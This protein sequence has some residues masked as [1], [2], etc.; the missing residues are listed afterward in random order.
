MPH[1]FAQSNAQLDK[2][3]VNT[4][5]LI[6]RVVDT[7]MSAY[8]L[9]ETHKGLF[10]T[11]IGVH[12]SALVHKPYKITVLMPLA[13]QLHQPVYN[14]VTFRTNVPNYLKMQHISNIP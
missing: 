5:K 8:L 3:C 13:V 7:K 9:D 14:D 1:L 12:H 6:L 11:W 4:M 2:N 10:A